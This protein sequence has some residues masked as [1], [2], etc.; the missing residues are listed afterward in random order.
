MVRSWELISALSHV[1]HLKAK[2]VTNIL[3][4]KAPS[5]HYIY[6][7][8]PILWEIEKI[9]W[10]IQFN[11]N[12]LFQLKK[13]HKINSNNLHVFLKTFLILF[14]FIED[15][16]KKYFKNGNYFQGCSDPSQYSDSTPEFFL[17][18]NRCESGPW[19]SRKG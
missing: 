10:W 5:Y 16:V 2:P 14:C 12:R 17:V 19:N 4:E 8:W 11:F 1:N 13:I 6:V 3:K 18:V 15:A 9:S 7:F